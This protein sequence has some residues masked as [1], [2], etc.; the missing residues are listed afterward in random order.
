MS[1][2]ADNAAYYFI[3]KHAS[4]PIASKPAYVETGEGGRSLTYS[5]LGQ[6]SNR[7]N[8]LFERHGLKR[9]DR[10]AMLVLDQIEFPIIFWGCIKSGLI[11]VPL[12]TLLSTEVYGAILSDC[13][14]RALFVSHEMLPMVNP[15]IEK[16][17]SLRAVF[18]IGNGKAKSD[19]SLFDKLL[20]S[21]DTKI[22]PYLTL[23]ER[24]HDCEER[25]AIEVSPDEI[26]FWLY[27]SGSTGT[28]KGVQHVHGSLKATADTYGREILK[29]RKDDIV[30][31]V[32]KLFFAYGL[33]NA[34]SFP[35]SVGATTILYSARPT[36]D[37]AFDILGAH[38]PSIFC[39]VPTLYAA[40]L[41]AHEAQPRGPFEN[42]RLCISAGEALP[43]DIGKRW[44]DAF[45]TEILDG[46]GSTEMLHIFL[47]NAP[48]DVEY[49]TSG[50]PVPGYELRLVDENNND[51]AIGEIGEMLVNG[52]S[53]ADS[54]WNQREKSRNTFEGVWTRTGDKYEQ[55]PDGRY[56]YC[57][58]TDDMFKVS[59]IWVSPFEVE[60]ALI[61]HP[62]I[63]EAAVIAATDNEGLDKPKAFVILKPNVG[64]DGLADALKTHV[65]EKI[66]KWKYPRWIEFLDELPK[67]STG[68]I[69]RF[70][71]RDLER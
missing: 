31:S 71:L 7:F 34:M 37:I 51:A 65:Q 44:Q 10:A 5:E 42:L 43:E 53:G 35:L 48:G 12:N 40:M 64:R 4:G 67:T 32:A 23:A 62:S 30:Y 45:G 50:K 8:A 38:N 28:P 52:A 6:Q 9:E 24:L 55:R 39:G 61:S 15:L 70:A 33:G 29:I 13:R 36:P 20:G 22:L 68:K 11:P 21:N 27:S 46:V 69:K 63:L 14:P 57:G 58:R 3:D 49:G 54:Y 18:V 26:A 59:G 47:S 19:S 17:G 41:A 1:K 16:I 60:Q 2:N 25:E 56:L 66:G